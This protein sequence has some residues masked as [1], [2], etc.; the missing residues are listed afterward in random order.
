MSLITRLTIGALSAGVL[1]SPVINAHTAAAQPFSPLNAVDDSG[2]TGSSA[3]V[4]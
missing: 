3:Q 2:S 4:I 1:L